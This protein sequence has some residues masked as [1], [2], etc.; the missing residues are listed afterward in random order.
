MRWQRQET[1][2]SQFWD[3]VDRIKRLEVGS[4][5]DVH[6]IGGAGEPGFQHGWVNA[7]NSLGSPGA[8]AASYRNAG[9][10]RSGGRVYLTGL[11]KGGTAGTVAFTLPAGYC[12]TAPDVAFSTPGAGGTGLIDVSAGGDVTI[13]AGSAS[14]ATYV[15]LDGIDFRHA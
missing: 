14:V 7:D 13:N 12:P 11:I 1:D 3:L 6:A 9:Y 4:P 15:Y 10:Y 2:A 5:E 8:P